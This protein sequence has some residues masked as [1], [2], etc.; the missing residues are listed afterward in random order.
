MLVLNQNKESVGTHPLVRR[1][2]RCSWRWC[3]CCAEG[4]SCVSWQNWGPA[5]AV[6]PPPAPWCPTTIRTASSSSCVDLRHR[7]SSARLAL[8]WAWVTKP[9]TNLGSSARLAL[10]SARVIRTS[11]V[12]GTLILDHM[13]RLYSENAIFLI[14]VNNSRTHL[15][16]IRIVLV[17]FSWTLK[18]WEN[19]NQITN[20]TVHSPVALVNS[21]SFNH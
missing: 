12:Q 21:F 14:K 10:H 4:C 11:G 9:Y 16:P 18:S 1:Q 17:C 7:E 8:H 19:V 20:K 3:C 6:D 2:S 13:H 15:L 5:R